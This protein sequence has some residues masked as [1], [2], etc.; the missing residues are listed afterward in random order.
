MRRTLLLLAAAI[1]LAGCG[2]QHDASGD[3]RSALTV[4][5]TVS[6]GVAGEVY[7]EGCTFA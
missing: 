7:I 3:P 4:R 2:G 6:P 1:M 5:S